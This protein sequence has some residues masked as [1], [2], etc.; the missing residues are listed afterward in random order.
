MSVQLVIVL[1]LEPHA[2][3][4]AVHAIGLG[5]VVGNSHRAPALVED[6]LAVGALECCRCLRDGKTRVQDLE[7]AAEVGDGG[8]E[9][10]GAPVVFNTTGSAGDDVVPDVGESG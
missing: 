3:P 8:L 5:C 2:D 10:L 7:G 9:A 1:L 4:I 6:P